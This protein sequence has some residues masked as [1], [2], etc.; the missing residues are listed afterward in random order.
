MAERANDGRPSLR[1]A[2]VHLDA[3][4]ACAQMV[5]MIRLLKRIA[6]ALGAGVIALSS[7]SLAEPTGLAIGGVDAGAVLATEGARSGPALWKVSDED[8]TIYLFGT[9]HALPGGLS[10]MDGKV[11]AALDSADELVTEVDL[12]SEA[13]LKA[14]LAEKGLLPAG[15][16]LRGLLGEE[17]RAAYETAVGALGLPVEAFDRMKP[18]YAGLMLSMIPMLREGFSPDAGVENVLDSHVPADKPR[19][20]LETIDF[21][22]NLFD[23]LPIEAQL[24]Y[25][26][27]VVAAAPSQAESLKAMIA[28]WME[29]DAEGLARLINAGDNDPQFLERLLYS[30]NRDWAGWIERRLDQPGT[31]FVAV[32][33]GHLAGKESVQEALARR[34]IASD[35]VQ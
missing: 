30:R 18:W 10:W 29:G 19:G 28:E 8:T 5:S 33:A 1:A 17:D 34:G 22:L 32:G 20:A 7:P 2:I 12:S 14:G 26:R 27:E 35:R 23:S 31:V 16:T 13:L 15:Q 24:G 4:V 21:Q 9:V 25:L 11:A 3:T 6:K